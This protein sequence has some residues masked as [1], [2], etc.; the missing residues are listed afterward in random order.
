MKNKKLIRKHQDSGTIETYKGSESN[1][2]QLNE[3]ETKPE[4]YQYDF[5]NI[6]DEDTRKDILDKLGYET[7]DGNLFKEYIDMAREDILSMYSDSEKRGRL[8]AYLD[9]LQGYDPDRLLTFDGNGRVYNEKTGLYEIPRIKFSGDMLND[10]IKRLMN[11]WYGSGR[12]PVFSGLSDYV[13]NIS[14]EDDYMG[15]KQGRAYITPDNNGNYTGMYNINSLRQ[16]LAEAS[17]FYQN[18]FPNKL[19]SE[20]PESWQ[21]QNKRADYN[22]RNGLRTHYADPTH[23]EHDTHSRKQPQLLDYVLYGIY[24]EFLRRTNHNLDQYFENNDNFHPVSKYE[25]N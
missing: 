1:P 19:V 9:Q 11:I 16:F 15:L 22:E 4:Q 21:Q 2:V 6:F 17:H 13:K 3:I 24:P 18:N 25:T 23:Y 8:N 20:S 12:I 7:I 10:R 14:D 5:Q